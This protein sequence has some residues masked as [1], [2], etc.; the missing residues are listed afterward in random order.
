[1]ALVVGGGAFEVAAGNWGH[2]HKLY[3]LSPLPFFALLCV[4]LSVC[5]SLKR[6]VYSCPALLHIHE[7]VVDTA[8]TTITYVGLEVHQEKHVLHQ[9]CKNPPLLKDLTEKSFIK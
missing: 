6:F 8:S 4:C 3:Q 5:Q 9:L 7:W 1:M 2:K